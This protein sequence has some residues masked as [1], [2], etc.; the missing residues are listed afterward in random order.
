MRR[1]PAHP[2]RES[3]TDQH[4]HGNDHDRQQRIQELRAPRT[5]YQK[6]LT[7]L[8]KAAEEC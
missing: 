8:W 2:L 5:P 6:V 4:A 7:Y 3:R 1:R